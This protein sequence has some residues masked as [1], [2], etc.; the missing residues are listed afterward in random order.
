MRTISLDTE[1]T[2]FDFNEGHRIV[3][4]GCVEMEGLIR[5]GNRFH[6]YINPER[7]VPEEAYKVHGLDYKFLKDKPLFVDISQD[8]INFIADSPL[9]IH[10]AQFDMAFLNGEFEKAGLDLIQN[11]VIDTL[12][13][14]RK[15]LKIGRYSLDALCNYYK[16]D[17]TNRT[18]HGALIDADLL[19]QVYLE[20][21]GGAE[22]KM[23]LESNDNSQAFEKLNSAINDFK[24][25]KTF[26]SHNNFPIVKPIETEICNHKTF[27]KEN[28]IY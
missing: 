5:T 26:I 17:K 3:E 19:A 24:E 22:L 8:F 11:E 15:R 12:T 4:I 13:L 18:L 21:E 10:N 6:V 28:E 20:L 16:I 25:E 9:V 27:L 7:E 1:T 2:G 23:E 14:A